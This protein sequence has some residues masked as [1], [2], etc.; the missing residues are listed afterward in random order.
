MI[1]GVVI[2][3]LASSHEI[4]AIDPIIQ[5]FADGFGRPLKQSDEVSELG[6]SNGVKI[7]AGEF[8]VSLGFSNESG[9]FW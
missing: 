8:S 2:R 5:G 4:A 3:E 7:Q 9:A 6:S 1:Q